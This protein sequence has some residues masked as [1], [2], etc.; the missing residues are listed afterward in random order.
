MTGREGLSLRQRVVSL[1]ILMVQRPVECSTD[2]ARNPTRGPRRDLDGQ[3]ARAATFPILM[4]GP[5]RRVVCTSTRGDG[6]AN[7]R[8]WLFHPRPL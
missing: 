8:Q 4:L 6:T 7:W 1:I 5:C 2:T 3:Y